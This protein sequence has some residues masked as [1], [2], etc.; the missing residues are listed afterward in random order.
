[1]ILSQINP[2]SFYAG[3]HES[4]PFSPNPVTLELSDEIDRLY[5]VCPICFENSGEHNLKICRKH[6]EKLYYGK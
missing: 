5:S 4:E 1:M 6:F 2:E 3:F